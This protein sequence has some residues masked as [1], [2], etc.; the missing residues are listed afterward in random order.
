MVEIERVD[1]ID[2]K[3]LKISFIIFLVYVSYKMISF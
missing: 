2:E 1:S 3:Y